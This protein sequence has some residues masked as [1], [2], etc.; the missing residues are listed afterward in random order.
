MLL[1]K[2]KLDSIAVLISKA[3]IDSYIRHDVF[4]SVNNVLR[5]Y[6]EI[7]KRHRKYWKLWGIDCI[8]VADITGRRTKEMT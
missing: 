8:D 3:L 4:V 7:K 6:N 1:E 5:N 2:A